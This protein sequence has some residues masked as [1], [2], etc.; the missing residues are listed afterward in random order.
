VADEL[1]VLSATAT[2]GGAGSGGAAT[3]GSMT[4]TTAAT[5]PSAG[6]SNHARGRGEETG[7]DGMGEI[8]TPAN[9][10]PGTTR[11]I[12]L[13][14]ASR[15][16]IGWPVLGVPDRR[17]RGITPLRVALD[18]TALL[19]NRTGVGEVAAAVLAG[20]RDRTDVDP[21]AYAISWR[22]RDQLATRAPGVSTATRPVPAA[23]VHRLWAA[24]APEPRL[25]RW[26]GPVDVVHGLNYVVPPTRAAAVVLVHD[27]S[28]IRFPE[29]CTPATLRFA[30]LLRRALD[31]GAT[32]H[33]PSK[34]VAEEVRA[35]L[36]VPADRVVPIHS[37]IPEVGAGDAAR[38]ARLAGGSR[39]VLAIGTIEPRKNLPAL[40]RAFGAAA[41]ADPDVRLVVAGP[42]GGDVDAFAAAVSASPARDRVIR[43]PYVEENTRADLLAGATVFAYPS[44]YE[45]FGFPPLEAMRA[46]VP[47]VAAHAGSLPEVL[48]DAADMVDPRDDDAL[49][50]ALVR[51]LT[52]SARREEL[53]A[54]GRARAAGYSW[55]ATI[56]HVV[57]LYRRLTR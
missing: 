8:V 45:G 38:G 44:L 9:P 1:S 35:E 46:G 22:A 4:D 7:E 36:G 6:A 40:V 16:P 23:L 3:A 31:R 53:V 11:R 2:A 24:G 37:G 26:T 29:L 43:L 19:G 32:V 12:S 15:R 27:L 47:V 48:G 18:C 34:H 33:T 55:R 25:E 49:A 13:H 52:D 39:Y 42:D 56:E 5:V 20:L 21:V 41:A 17:L 50:A 57:D 51:V 14:A 30:P 54:R 28:F 10:C